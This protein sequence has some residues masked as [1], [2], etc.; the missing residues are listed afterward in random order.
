[1]SEKLDRAG[2]VA[3]TL[4]AIHCAICALLPAA[5]GALGLGFLLGHEV[6]LL[7]TGIAMV[8]ALV[9]L[10]IGFRSHGSVRVAVLLALGIVGL[11]ASR[12]L[13]MGSDHHG[14]HGEEHHAEA[15]HHDGEDHKGDDHKDEE[16]KDGEHAAAEK[17]AEH[18]EHMMRKVKN[19]TT[20]CTS[21]VRGLAFLAAYFFSL[22][23]LQTSVRADG[24]KSK[25]A[26]DDCAPSF[27]LM[28]RH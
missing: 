15:E 19:M 6:E 11:L 8:F 4:C 21:S 1:M 12:G 20:P 26:T 13:E 9:A 25:A 22:A 10:V 14:H 5:F 24:A 7:L 27:E 2:A 17:K 3:S 18:G 16:H 23:T 28:L